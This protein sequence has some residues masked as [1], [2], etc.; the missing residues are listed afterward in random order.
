[1]KFGIVF[2]VLQIGVINAFSQID[3]LIH[4][5]KVE[6]IDVN[7]SPSSN[8]SIKSIDSNL[9]ISNANVGL[10]ELLSKASDV[11]IKDYGSGA[12]STVSFRGM[13]S[14]H[15]NVY[16]NGI[17]LNSS[18]NGTFDLSLL[19]MNSTDNVVVHYGASSLVDGSG[20]LGG[21]IKLENKPRYDN[22][23]HVGVSQSIGSFS[24]YKTLAKIQTSTNKLF[25]D[26]RFAYINSKNEFEYLNPSKEGTPTETMIGA[27]Y[28]NLNAIVNAGWLLNN[29]N[30]LEFH[31]ILQN[32]NRNLPKL[33]LQAEVRENQKD[34]QNIGFLEWK[35]FGNTFTND[36]KV[37][38]KSSDIDY[39]NGNIQLESVSS[40][41]N[42]F[43]QDRVKYKLFKK[44]N[45][46]SSF[47]YDYIEAF[48]D[49]YGVEQTRNEFQMI[50]DF[51]MNIY[52][53]WK[54]GILIKSH[55]TTNVSLPFL[56][57]VNI[58]FNAIKKLLTI[59]G[60]ASYHGSIPSMND[61][62]WGEG[63]NPNLQPEK[64]IST[65]L[66][67]SGTKELKKSDLNYQL[68]GYYSDID[69]W[70]LWSPDN[71]GIWRVSNVGNVKSYGIEAN[72]GFNRK[73]LKSILYF[74]VA[75]NMNV[76]E[77]QELKQLLYVPI[78]RFQLNLGWQWKSLALNY[79]HQFIDQRFINSQNSAWLPSYY[80]ADFSGSYEFKL[81]KENKIRT[82]L[83]VNNLYDEPF[84]SIANRPMP[85]R[86]Y[87]FTLTY[88]WK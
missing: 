63:G 29:S 73:I 13:G 59:S 69:D 40:E 72:F 44:V 61:L 50:H 17:A 66:N 56:P 84:Q 27:N 49:K 51:Q 78:H 52:K 16:W 22:S 6:V 20:S 14:S 24:T 41:N 65:E 1:M 23:T 36:F 46:S 15:T 60:S 25:I 18:M 39:V 45:S 9:L 67:F 86:Y 83:K 75:Y 71:S 79:N 3:T 87:T 62:Y 31:Y 11:F 81:K 43:I 74:K 54:A 26:V 28:S 38:I 30:S 70:I 34:F 48:N 2:I 58:G 8:Y 88:L 10:D 5:P 57:S 47:L 4:L 35:N 82:S 64:G 42:L 80:L 68:S 33:N 7:V 55:F 76:S 12:L 32:S 77:D 19:N 53:K 37:G 85:G 21:S